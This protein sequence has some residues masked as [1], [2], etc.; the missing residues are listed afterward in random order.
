MWLHLTRRTWAFLTS[1]IVLLGMVAAAVLATWGFAAIAD[2]VL[3]RDTQRFDRWV[4]T[5]LRSGD[6]LTDTWGPPWLEHA[7]LEVTVLG[8]Q[9]VFVLI[10]AAVAVYLMLRRFWMRAALTVGAIVVGAVMV[11]L[12]KAWFDRPRPDIV[13]HLTVEESLSFPSG[14]ATMS[15]VVYLTLGLLLAQATPRAGL[16][17]YFMAVAMLLVLMV[18]ASRVYLGVHYPTDVLAGWCV[19]TAWAAL[20]WLV[21]VLVHRFSAREKAAERHDLA[22]PYASGSEASPERAAV[23][24]REFVVTR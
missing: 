1:E 16:K 13:P 19:G 10:T 7:A 8:G 20:A 15:A 17:A 14:H 21:G 11:K 9:T 4:M 18:G 5:S 3:D 2:E 12:M 24:A 23:G 6:D 22:G